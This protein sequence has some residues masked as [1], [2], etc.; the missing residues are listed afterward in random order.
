MVYTCSLGG[1]DWVNAP[2]AATPDTAFIR[3]SDQPPRSPGTWQHRPISMLDHFG[4]EG[5][6]RLL[7]RFAKL[8]AHRLFPEAE[9]SIWIDGN[10]KILTDLTPLIDRFR[11]TG[12][13]A[14][15]FPHPSGRTA[16][17]EMVAALGWGRIGSAH[18][19]RA[20]R[21]VARYAEAGALDDRVHETSIVFRRH[22][23]REIG[24][25]ADLWWDELT[26]FTERDQVSLPFVLQRSGLTVHDWDF[27]F[28]DL[29]NPY[30]RRV[31]HR[32]KS[33]LKRVRKGIRYQ[34]DADRTYKLLSRVADPIE[35]GLRLVGIRFQE[36]M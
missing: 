30:F 2:L 36:P 24:A 7:A 5:G 20:A 29:V 17:E 22:D 4:I 34:A 25:F 16:L 8:Y 23:A 1:Y 3:I 32:P 28:A 15:F 19:D 13:A 12:A 11:T 35:R 26:A 31:P 21:Q 9:L 33:L 14:A 18:F 6:P 10:I 27:H